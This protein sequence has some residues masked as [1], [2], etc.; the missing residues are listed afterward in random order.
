[1]GVTI[2]GI[3]ETLANLGNVPD[4]VRGEVKDGLNRALEWGATFATQTYKTNGTNETDTLLSSSDIRDHAS[5]RDLSGRL[6]AGGRGEWGDAEYAGVVEFGSKPHFPPVEALTGEVE[7]LDRWVERTHKVTV[8]ADETRESVAFLI[9]REIDERGNRAQ[10]FMRPANAILKR[11]LPGV[12]DMDLD[13][14][15]L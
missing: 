4:E 11:K 10:P 6:G 9:A 8:G 5:K 1:M 14:L 7:P 2:Q 13:N 3:D 15:N 12:M